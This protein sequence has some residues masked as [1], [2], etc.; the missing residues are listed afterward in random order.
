MDKALLRKLALPAVP[1]QVGIAV[2]SFCLSDAS[3]VPFRATPTLVT[4][5]I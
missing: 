5:S 1:G 2:G 3:E 4:E